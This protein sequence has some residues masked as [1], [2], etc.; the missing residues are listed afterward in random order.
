MM[1][2]FY[3]LFLFFYPIGARLLSF[4]NA[5]A[6]KWIEGRKDIFNRLANTIS[7]DKP[8]AWIHCASLGEFEQAR[9]LIEGLRQRF[10]GLR[11]LLTFFSPSG[12]E[13]QKGYPGV[14][15][16]FYLPLDSAENAKRFLDITHPALIVFVKYE[17]WFYYISEAGRRKIPL[18]LA[19]GAFREGQ[20]FFKWYGGFHREMLRS[21]SCLFLQD[22]R[23]VELLAS[24]GVTNI[25]LTGD[26]RFDRVLAIAADSRPIDRVADFCGSHPVIVAGSTWTEDDKEL[27]HYANTNPHIRFIIAPHDI[28]EPRISECLSLYKHSTTF[29]QLIEQEPTINDQRANVLIIDNIGLLSRLY[30]YATIAYVGGGF[31]GDG[32]H[33]VLEAAVYG[34]PVVFGPVYDKYVEAVMLE[35]S[36]G[37]FPVNNAL[38]LE[39]QFNQL[40]DDEFLYKQAGLAAGEFVGKNAGATE[41][42]LDYIQEKRLLTT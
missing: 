20:P 31:G 1:K 13:V 7:N 21:F 18:I 37:G 6:G 15:H 32:V 10:P 22:Q 36:G 41:K 30:R 4:T 14:D 5:K 16:V 29:S 23:S 24:I 3:N 28:S 8:F 38:E 19:S 25:A 26:T 11:L 27:D 9:P 33:N 42:I 35:E 17:F 34:K 39:K 40:L 2:A 12:Y